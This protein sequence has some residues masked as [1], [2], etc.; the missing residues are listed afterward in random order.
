[1]IGQV[2]MRLLGEIGRLGLTGLALGAGLAAAGCA[3]LARVTSLAP[4][5]VDAASPVAQRVREASAADYPRPRFR[6]IPPA[7][8]DVRPAEAWRGAVNQTV[9]AGSALTAWVAANPTTVAAGAT[10]TFAEGQRASIP[11]SE[12]EAPPSDPAGTEA[13][14]A[15][16]R[17]MAAPPPPPN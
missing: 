11:A 2:E 8:V 14:A 1:M 4:D 3:D 10:E 6:D 5:P 16:L 13:F 7:P 9:Q 15:R 17:A 12:R